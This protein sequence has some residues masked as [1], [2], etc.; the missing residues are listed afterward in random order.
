MTAPKKRRGGPGGKP[1]Y[2]PETAARRA[3]GKVTLGLS[4]E[5]AAALR[6]LGEHHAG[7]MAGV[8]SDWIDASA[9]QAAVLGEVD[10][11]ADRRATR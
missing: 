1:I 10:E 9:Q 11:V 8:V 4:P 5:R 7:G 3:A 2:S 6:S